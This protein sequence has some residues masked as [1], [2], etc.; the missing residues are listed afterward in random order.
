M[1]INPA[2]TAGRMQY[3]LD[4]ADWSVL[5]TA[6]GEQHRAGGTYPNE[7]LFW[8]TSG[9]TGD[10]KFC[11]FT[12][13][14]LRHVC[15]QIIQ[16][17]DLTVNDRYAS[18]MPLW[19]AH[20]QMF[21]W[22]SRLVGFETTFLPINQLPEL[23]TYHPTFI[24]AIPDI[25]RAVM[26]QEFDSLRFVRSASASLPGQLYTDMTERLGVPV[27][28]SFGMTETCSH[29]FTNPLYGEQ[30]VGTVGLPSG[31][32]ARIENN[33]LFVAGPAVSRTG[34]FDTGDLA[35]QD[36][37]GY[38]KILG[39]ARDRINV[40]G[41][42]LDPLSLES[43]VREQLPELGE[44]AVFGTDTVKCVYSGP[45]KI[46]DVTQALL[47]LGQHCRPSLVK[48]LVEIPKNAAGKVSRSM[49]DAIY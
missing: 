1:L 9:T 28:E 19:H 21:Y 16:D 29:C 45:Y 37:A 22:V 30:R 43:Q 17:Y 3:L 48:Q 39:R 38:Y 33:R 13:D 36:S 11:S 12:A 6:T 7:K 2:T 26:K 10:S 44:I 27:I 25:L 24:T 40:R 49:L 8:Y 32:E 20:G 31:I 35:E 47:S 5:V 41:Y 42:K 14:Q 18:V 46:S 23:H 34:W 4:N 15:Q